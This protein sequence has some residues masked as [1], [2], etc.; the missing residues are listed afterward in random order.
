M[1]IPMASPASA[2][3][4]GK[5]HYMAPE[6]ARGESVSAAADVYALGA[7]L[8]A[9][10]GGGPHAPVTSDA[11]GN[12]REAAARSRGVSLPVCA[13]IRACL[14]RDA[15]LRPSSADVAARAGVL[16]SQML[17]QNDGRGALRAWLEPLRARMGQ[18]GALDNLMGLCL[19]PV[20][21]DGARTFTVS[22]VWPTPP[23]RSRPR[24]AAQD[25]S[26]S[27]LVRG[28]G[29][30]DCLRHHG[31]RVAD[32]A[33]RA[34]AQTPVA[35]DRAAA[36]AAASNRPAAAILPSASWSPPGARTA[37]AAP[38]GGAAATP[39]EAPARGWLRIGGATLVGAPVTADGTFLGFVPMEVSLPA[40]S[41]CDPGD[42]RSGPRPRA[43]ADSS[44]RS[45]DPRRAA[46]DF[47]LIRKSV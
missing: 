31:V 3:C 9:L 21:G 39:A 37:T 38:S 10:L 22:R 14:A 11:S 17:G 18:M 28:G 23:A 43:Q 41:A 5:L 16:A 19:V 2:A 42:V 12:A 6:Q 15:K 20:S 26:R 24:R 34:K 40:G 35:T 8:D 36:S 30:D 44:T 27:P 25:R 7:T 33:P 32:R 47:A 13:L 46:P 1:T 4:R 45:A 29:D